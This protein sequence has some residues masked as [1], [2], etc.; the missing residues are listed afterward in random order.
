MHNYCNVHSNN[1]FHIY[2]CCYGIVED[3][4]L[5]LK[6]NSFSSLTENPTMNISVN[7]AVL[8]FHTY[9]FSTTNNGH[10]VRTSFKEPQTVIFTSR[11]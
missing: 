10:K 8:V 7:A 1:I 6:R 4:L 11:I 9:L 5:L 3:I 2:I